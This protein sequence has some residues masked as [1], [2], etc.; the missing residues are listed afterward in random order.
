MVLKLEVLRV[1][2]IS[3][4]FRMNGLPYGERVEGGGMETSMANGFI[5]LEHSPGKGEQKELESG[6]L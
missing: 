1:E 2:M 6:G 4:A 3:E 5:R